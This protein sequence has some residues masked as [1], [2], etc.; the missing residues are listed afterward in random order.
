METTDN[1]IIELTELQREPQYKILSDRNGV[2]Y[3]LHETI[4]HLLINTGESCDTE[5]L[6]GYIF[7]EYYIEQIKELYEIDPLLL[8]EIS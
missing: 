1:I 8:S 6:T 5:E 4:P 2:M 3:Y 7:E